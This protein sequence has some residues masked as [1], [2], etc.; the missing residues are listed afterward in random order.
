MLT[1]GWMF[2]SLSANHNIP[3]GIIVSSLFFTF[4]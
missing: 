3:S 1:S 4:L 2:S